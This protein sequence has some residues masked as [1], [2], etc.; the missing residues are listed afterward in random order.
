M[1]N[2]AIFDGKGT[3]QSTDGSLRGRSY[4][5]PPAE[6]AVADSTLVG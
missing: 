4:A 2:T 5:E 3:A 6:L 1:L